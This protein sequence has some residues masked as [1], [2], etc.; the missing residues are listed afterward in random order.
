MMLSRFVFFMPAKAVASAALQIMGVMT[1]V[2][3]ERSIVPIRVKNRG[4][5]PVQLEFRAMSW[6]LEAGRSVMEKTLD[7]IAAPY[8]L[9]APAGG[10]VCF[11]LCLRAHDLESERA[12]KLL[13][14]SDR[15]PEAVVDA[16]SAFVT[17]I[18][19][20]ATLDAR[21]EETANGRRLVLLNRG[22]ARARIAHVLDSRAGLLSSCFYLLSGACTHIPLPKDARLITIAATDADG[23]AITRSIDAAA[24]APVALLT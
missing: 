15:N 13:I 5:L 24:L 7:L 8:L 10:E 14:H 12:Y 6:R 22:T 16:A 1:V 2:C 17:P 3:A 11:R 23:S 9:D 18:G 19:A 21:I 4:P 20:H